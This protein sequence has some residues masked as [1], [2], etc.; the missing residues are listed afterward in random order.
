MKKFFILISLLFTII[1]SSCATAGNPELYAYNSID[2]E[3]KIDIESSVEIPEVEFFISAPY[4]SDEVHDLPVSSPV[5][6]PDETAGDLFLDDQTKNVSQ[7]PLIIQKEPSVPVIQDSGPDAVMPIGASSSNQN[8]EPAPVEIEPLRIQSVPYTYKSKAIPFGEDLVLDI[9]R[10]GWI[11]DT[12]SSPSIILKRREFHNGETRFI[13]SVGAIEEV[14]LI[15]SL[16]NPSSGEDE[17]LSYTISIESSERPFESP[18]VIN[19]VIENHNSGNDTQFDQDIIDSI[20]EENIPE[21]IASFD[22]LVAD[23]DPADSDT[24]FNAF[25]LLERQGGY[26]KYLIDLAENVY[27]L[28]PY[29]N[30]SAEM[31]FKA[32]QSIEKPGPQQNIEK[33]LQLFKLVRDY[34]PVSIYC[35][36]SEERIRYL[37]RHFMKIY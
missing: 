20:E 14:E 19:P 6:L 18:I 35:D 32:A 4:D 27:R 8:R 26:D 2:E 31:L 11:F 25:T 36:K 22:Q 23:E 1:L 21:I 17:K 13:F 7:E 29:D 28:Y 10:E 12:S 16:Q 33:A 30:L 34:F 5:E 3:E 24:L 15:F 9:E 37:E